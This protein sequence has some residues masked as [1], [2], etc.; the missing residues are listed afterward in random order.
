V[1]GAVFRAVNDCRQGMLVPR[2][3]VVRQPVRHEIAI[4][5]RIGTRARVAS[6]VL[7]SAVRASP[8]SREKSADTPNASSAPDVYGNPRGRALVLLKSVEVS[9]RTGCGSPAAS[10][11]GQAPSCPRRSGTVPPTTRP[12]CSS[13]TRANRAGAGCDRLD[14]NQAGLVTAGDALLRA[15]TAPLTSPMAPGSWLR[16]P[17][18]RA[19]SLCPS[20]LTRVRVT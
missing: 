5:T 14:T 4:G 18:A 3:G 13:V 19:G 9:S 2:P 17:R 10:R 11:C 1:V 7:F 12:R 20:P 8:I 6:A 16:W 15:A